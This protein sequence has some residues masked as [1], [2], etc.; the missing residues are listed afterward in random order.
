MN[1]II[2]L[3]LYNHVWNKWFFINYVA[4]ILWFNGKLNLKSTY[5]LLK[6]HLDRRHKLHIKINLSSIYMLLWINVPRN[7]KLTLIKFRSVK[8]NWNKFFQVKSQTKQNFFKINILQRDFA[9]FVIKKDEKIWQI[10]Y[11]FKSSK[12]EFSV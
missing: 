9:K 1:L 2:A 4:P 5:V 10:I 8:K 12:T 7:I 3:S 6:Y 11:L